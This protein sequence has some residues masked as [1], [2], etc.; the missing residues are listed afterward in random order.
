MLLFAVLPLAAI[1]P[2]GLS[3]EDATE[4]EHSLQDESS[5]EIE[6]QLRHLNSR[7]GDLASYS[8]RTGIGRVGYRSR[9]HDNS[10]HLEWVEVDLEREEIIDQ[11]IIVPTIWK[12]SR[13]GFTADGFPLA[14]DV[15]VKNREYPEGTPIASF[16][17]EDQLLPRIAPVVIDC[18]KGTKASAVRLEAS[19]LSSRI[20]DGRFLLQLAEIM[21]FKGEKNVAL[22]KTIRTEHPDTLGDF[23]RSRKA[24]VDGFLPYVMDAA[25]GN[26]SL[27]MVGIGPVDSPPFSLEIDLGSTCLLD[28][29][30]LHQTDLS[31]T[32]PQAVPSDFGIPEKFMIEGASQPDFSDAVTL[33]TYEKDSV[34]DVGPILMWNIRPT[35]CRFVR[36]SSLRPYVSEMGDPSITQ[37]GFAE[38][39]LF[40]EGKNVALE[41]PARG[42]FELVSIERSMAALTDGNNFY[43]AI[44]PIR[45]WMNQLAERHLLETKRPLLMKEQGRRFQ[46]QQ[47]MLTLLSWLTAIFAAGILFTVLVSRILRMRE[48][49]SIRERLAAD[50]HDELGATLHTIGL[51]S[52]LAYEARGNPQEMEKLHSRIRAET[53]RSGTAVRHS[54]DI[55]EAKGLHSDLKAD[56]E[57]A[58]QRILT[59]E[60]YMLVVEGDENLQLLKSRKRADLFLF[61]KECLINV[62][63][64]AEAEKVE[65]YLRAT[66]N[67]IYMS[68]SDD[69]G[70]LNNPGEHV[71]PPSLSRRARLLK[72]LVTVDA[73]EGRGT[74]IQ[75]KLK[76][77]T[78]SI[79]RRRTW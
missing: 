76:R 32:V 33:A 63:R 41:Q 54:V 3:A 73:K 19:I 43:G 6:N 79:Q 70:G 17:S 66:P 40:S 45:A 26:Q 75:L 37:I 72:G 38:I 4:I 44:L 48:A 21:V 64:H 71:V 9:T 7:L 57:R 49:A 77:P 11:I 51:L 56:M 62:S 8:L 69:G 13:A 39:E 59:H 42:N 10:N 12:D 5:S 28:Q 61:F 20:W 36:L 53:E 2:E 23:G 1:C 65:A 16:D 47:A 18:P 15:V 35:P 78:F 14:F 50:L 27:A 46:R 60:K 55:L 52:D 74:E 34:F 58:A 31:D 67:E 68:I 29:I 24:L 25:K 22:R 30:H